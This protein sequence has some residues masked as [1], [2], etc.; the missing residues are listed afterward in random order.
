MRY[1]PECLNSIFAQT[2]RDFH[3]LIID[4]NSEDGTVQFLRNNYPDISIIQNNKNLGFPKGNNQGIRLINSPYVVLCNPDILMELNW[5][6]MMVDLAD[7]AEN[8]KYGSFG[9]KLLK[10]KVIG[11][12]LN[13]VEK[14]E[15]ID[16]CGLKLLRDHRVVEIGG[17]EDTR[18]VLQK[19]EVFGH[20][21]ALVMY[22]KE[23]LADCIMKYP[24][25]PDGECFDEDFFLY[26]E[27]VD[28]A[29]RLQLM[30]WKSLMDPSIIA[31][32]VRSVN[33][34]ENRTVKT[35]LSNRKTQ[36]RLARF[37][38]Y[39]NHFLTLIKNE[40]FSNLMKYFPFIFFY[41]FK[42]FIYIVFFETESLKSLGQIISLWPKMQKKRKFI[43]S[44][45]RVEAN[46]IR[47]WI[48]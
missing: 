43:F 15:V 25:A 17:G 37:Y 3:V 2:F 10:L 34:S 32:H 44:V 1:L 14:T 12:D 29:W 20:S 42:K 11:G 24:G 41:E 45:A 33:G 38:S 21:G 28:L 5:L 39:R 7:R 19:Q 4:N 6:E 8:S 27:D 13:E 40:T 30:G 35:I 23:A 31:Y 36:S 26:K 47:K 46:Y 48:N 18:A 22:R 9:G 16:S